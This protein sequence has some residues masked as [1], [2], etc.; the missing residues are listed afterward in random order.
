MPTSD[1][2]GKLLVDL[3]RLGRQGCIL[4]G[5]MMINSWGSLLIEYSAYA[6]WIPP[7]RVP[8]WHPQ[9]SFQVQQLLVE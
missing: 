1:V 2:L 7:S 5:E 6:S 9:H 4:Q 8:Y 3:S